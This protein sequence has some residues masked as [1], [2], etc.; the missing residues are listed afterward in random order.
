[1]TTLEN[2]TVHHAYSFENDQGTI[3]QCT[4][5][6]F[7][8]YAPKTLRKIKHLIVT[9]YALTEK[10]RKTFNQNKDTIVL[11]SVSAE[12]IDEI[13]ST[14]LSVPNQAHAQVCLERVRVKINSIAGA[15]HSYSD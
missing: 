11:D 1:M 4:G 2:F 5:G 10:Q 9:D 14:W 7:D 3:L 12:T 6:I 15:S 8:F 13:F